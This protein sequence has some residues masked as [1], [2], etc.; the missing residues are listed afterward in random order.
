MRLVDHFQRRHAHRTSWAMHQLDAFGEQ[1]VDSILDDGM[2]LPAADL[3]NYPRLTLDSLDF[4]DK[5]PRN[6]S[7]AIF[8]EI[9][10]SPSPLR[11]G[12]WPSSSTSGISSSPS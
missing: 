12:C 1:I 6:L 7:V 3:H 5:L 2:S 4:L 11:S 9:F 10:H 8:I